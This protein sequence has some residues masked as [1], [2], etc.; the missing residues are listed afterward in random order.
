ML[1]DLV[2]LHVGGNQTL[3]A[4]I[5]SYIE[6]RHYIPHRQLVVIQHSVLLTG[7][8]IY[9]CNVNKTKQIHGPMWAGVNKG[10]GIVYKETARLTLFC[11]HSPR[12]FARLAGS[13]RT[14]NVNYY[15]SG[16]FYSKT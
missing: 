2:Q 3:N 10:G 14:I 1:T 4:V 8:V 16:H 5:L 15:I 12:T 11:V 13:E 6:V 9:G 7:A